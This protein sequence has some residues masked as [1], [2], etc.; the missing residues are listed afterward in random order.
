MLVLIVVKAQSWVGAGASGRRPPGDPQLQPRGTVCNNPFASEDPW[1]GSRCDSRRS[2]AAQSSARLLHGQTQPLPA[3]GQVQAHRGSRRFGVPSGDRV[4]DLRVL[5]LDALKIS[6]LCFPVALEEVH[7]GAR[8][9][10]WCQLREQCTQIVITGGVDDFL[11][12]PDVRRD[13]GVGRTDVRADRGLPR[14]QSLAAAQ[15]RAGVVRP[16]AFV[17]TRP[18]TPQ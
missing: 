5:L 6:H 15:I 18:Q 3:V 13:G 2:G 9:Q 16:I 14:H 7:A 12:E 4:V 8:D 11:V 1:G 10:Q 17:Q